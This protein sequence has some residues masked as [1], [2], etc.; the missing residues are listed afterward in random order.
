MASRRGTVSRRGFVKAAGAAIAFPYAAPSGTFAAAGAAGPGERITMAHIGVG[1]MGTAHLHDMISRSARGRVA[2]AAVC[3]ADEKRLEKARGLTDRRAAAYRDYRFVL[4]RKDIDAVVIATPDH[5]HGVQT[6][7]A[8]ECGKHVYV[9]KPACCTIEEGKAMV[10]A[11]ARNKISVQVGSQGR[12]QPEAY[13]AHRYLVNN[14][15]K[16]HRVA[17]WHYASPVGGFEPDG[18]PPPELDWDLWLGP[19][20]WRPYNR[21][22]CPGTF[23]WIMESGGGQIRD[24]G[25]HVMSCAKYFT[26]TDG[27]GPVTVAA[28][29]MAP[30]RGLWDSAVHIDVTYTFKNPDW[31]LTWSQP[32]EPVPAEKRKPDEAR[33]ER[34]GYGAVYYGEKDTMVVWGGDGG[35]WAER[36]VRE[37]RPP[38]GAVDVYRSPGHMEDW[39]KG[40]RTGAETIMNIA[41]GVEVAFLC[42]LGNLSFLLG[43]EL[44]WDPVAQEIVGDEQARRMMSRPQRYPYTL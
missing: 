20:R 27:A 3:D 19:L 38:A 21:A 7:H 13:L 18:E 25:A 2:V 29:G 43:R 10:A 42:I 39:F 32:G 23:R 22:Y 1:G 16:V 9:E 24:R 5:W 41:A 31:V 44:T 4:E 14:L 33:I 36:K 28:T 37:W 30:A 26:G 12:S 15:G 8:A 6:V 34:P 17:C 35:T 11:A 40:I